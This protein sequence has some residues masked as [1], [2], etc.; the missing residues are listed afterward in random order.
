M[1]ASV[2]GLSS[3]GMRAVPP[4]RIVASP[5]GYAGGWP[6][7][8]REVI[9]GVMSAGDD[10]FAGDHGLPAS[11]FRVTTMP[12]T[13]VEGLD[14]SIRRRECACSSLQPRDHAPLR[15]PLFITD[16]RQ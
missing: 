16:T 9:H 13:C 8:L 3:I 14:R 12:G 1:S 4:S 15:P 11:D 5:I 10:L 2:W 6:F 7:R